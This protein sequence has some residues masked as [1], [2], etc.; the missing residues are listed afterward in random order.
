MSPPSLSG[1]GAGGLGEYENKGEIM[2]G[3]AMKTMVIACLGIFFC[4]SASAMPKPAVL[5]IQAAGDI[6]YSKD[7]VKWKKV[8]RN[9]FL[10]DG[11]HVRTGNNG[12]CK[13]LNQDAG[14]SSDLER[15]S[16]A[17]IR[18]DS[19]ETM[20][21]KISA[22]SQSTGVIGDITR[23]FATVQKYTAVLRAPAK[24]GEVKLDTAE[25]ITLS[26]DYP[27]LVW[28]NPGSEY[29]FQVMVGSNVHNVP[30][31][32]KDMIRF[33]LPEMTAGKYA[34]RVTLIHQGKEIFSPQKQGT[35]IWLSD[36]E[37]Q[38][39]NEE[40]KRIDQLDPGN[41]FL[42]GNYMDE[43][44]LSVAAMGHYERFFSEHPE[45]YEL[46]PFLIKVYADLRLEKLREK[47]SFAFRQQ[48]EP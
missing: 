12:L 31:S 32:G 9:K 28:E 17:I 40:L 42:I 14:T 5:L 48:T 35:L 10:F 36:K 18:T 24:P 39:V 7:G 41:G 45:E 23:K 47:E 21:G 13:L 34:Y 30:A 26:E 33:K 8:D 20:S 11:D 38:T 29:S 43:K 46:K 16:H 1:K 3:K 4:I 15:N 6:E 25:A 22:P 19:I 37:R 44:G 2:T 27:A